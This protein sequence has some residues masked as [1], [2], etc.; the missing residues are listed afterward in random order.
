MNL[1]KN[2]WNDPVWSKVIAY[3]IIY[4]L[5]LTISNVSQIDDLISKN[6][7]NRKFTTLE[8]YLL[9][10]VFS[11]IFLILIYLIVGYKKKNI[12]NTYHKK[13][14]QSVGSKLNYEELKTKYPNLKK[15]AVAGLGSVGKTTLIENLCNEIPTKEKTEGKGAYVVNLDNNDYKYAAILDGTGQRNEVQ[16]FIL[17][18][19]DIIIL[20][21]DHNI[22]SESTEID[23]QRIF[24]H[25]TFI[26]QAKDKLIEKNRKPSDIY[27]LLNKKDQ[28]KENSEEDKSN[29]INKVREI[30][31]LFQKAFPNSSVFFR[32][33]SN[34]Y[35]LDV[36]T[37]RH[38]LTNK[39]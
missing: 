27:I 7:L 9:I 25:T 13:F 8:F 5:T 10:A 12:Q 24:E 17:A 23:S 2:V 30:E 14:Y 32:K 38:N 33:F 11:L 1:S 15:I 22:N 20:I 37:L 18:E 19:A 4:V 6:L 28:W 26:G 39:L 31:E 29:L 34:D 16:N 3:A 36:T 35:S 21:V